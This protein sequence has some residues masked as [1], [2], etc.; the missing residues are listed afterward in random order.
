LTIPWV[1][2]HVP[3]ILETW[4]L[5]VEHG[6][7]VADVLFGDFNPSGKLPVTFPRTVGQVPI[8]YA[9]KNTGRPPSKDRFTS[10]YIDLPSTPLY[11]FG[12]GL[13]YTRLALS[14]LRMSS[15]KMGADGKLTVTVDVKNV[16]DL[17]GDEVVQLYVRNRV[18]SVT[19]PVKE[20][21][22][23]RRVSLRPG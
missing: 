10:K 14:G 13:S 8:Y 12:F 23:F 22:G 3:A 18:A 6:N 11:P 7:A 4:Q 15:A 5:G 16:G 2:E 9:H 21:K 20:L 17:P 19:R 1:A